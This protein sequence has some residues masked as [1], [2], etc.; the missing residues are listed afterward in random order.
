MLGAT[1]GLG[2]AIT[3][4]I[5]NALI[6]SQVGSL[7]SSQILLVRAMAGVPLSLLAVAFLSSDMITLRLTAD[8]WLALVG[9]VLL[10]YFGGDLIFVEALKYTSLA[11]GFPIQA[12]YPLL[13]VLLAWALGVERVTWMIGVGAVIVVAGVVL[14]SRETVGAGENHATLPGQSDLKG[15]LLSGASAVCWGA[16]AV[17]LGYGLGERHA[18][19]VNA[20]I[21]VLTA[22]CYLP[23]S[24]PVRTV[25]RVRENPRL[26]VNLGLAGAFGGTGVSNM[27]YVLAVDT[28]GVSR[29]A[30][31]AGTAPLFSAILAVMLLGERMTVNLAIGTLLNV[32]GIALLVGG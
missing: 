21:A 26:G 12:S 13:A 16:S 23:V 22:S 11:R 20:V 4:A 29:A 24:R 25:R 7:S 6:K 10:G 18:I 15:L 17:L 19:M 31:L 9:S 27:L 14:I 32:V 2:A 3:W 28:T 1:Y 8:V 5:G 30:V